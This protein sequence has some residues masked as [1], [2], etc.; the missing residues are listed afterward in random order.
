MVNNQVLSQEE[1][2]ALVERDTAVS[3]APSDT[4]E[5]P[6]VE[7]PPQPQE[8][9][10]AAS[11]AV[12]APP[13][14]PAAPVAATAASAAVGPPPASSMPSPAPQPVETVPMAPAAQAPH[15]AATADPAA[16]ERIA[17]LESALAE[18]DARVRQ[19]EASV[20]EA[21][22]Q[23][24]MLIATVQDMMGN[25][26]ATPAYGVQK[27]FTCG[28]C[29]AQGSVAIPVRCTNCN[30]DTMFGWWPGQ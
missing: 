3:A 21:A 16:Q 8:A 18:S 29:S 17:K 30:T 11:P 22:Q 13:Q 20:Q 19:V 12:A 15:S 9:P 6:A 7:A 1:I 14:A 24:Q 26:G 5:A 23:V 27:S 28:T 25:L 10:D 2:N 4:V